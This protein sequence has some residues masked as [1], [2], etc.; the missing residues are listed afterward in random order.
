M[1][2]TP[3]KEGR[4]LLFSFAFTCPFGGSNI[5]NFNV[6]S[7][8]RWHCLLKCCVLYTSLLFLLLLGS[9]II[10]HP[11]NHQP[12][13][14]AQNIWP[15]LNQQ[16]YTVWLADHWPLYKNIMDGFLQPAAYI[17]AL[18]LPPCLHGSRAVHTE[19]MFKW[20][21]WPIAASCTRALSA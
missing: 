13:P 10:S 5:R 19:P 15:L 8:S 6:S 3:G 12:L 21:S 16:D 11:F 1:L 9:M 2:S 18:Q 20:H 14:R 7:W 4:R 17:A